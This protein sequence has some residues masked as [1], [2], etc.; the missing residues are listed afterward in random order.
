MDMYLQD[1]EKKLPVS[2]NESRLENGWSLEAK[3]KV[4]KKRFRSRGTE[5]NCKY[6][7]CT[8]FSMCKI[9]SH[10]WAITREP[11]VVELLL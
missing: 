3:H 8:S 11:N 4:N 7:I 9:M 10:G 6:F 5:T 1:D 2:M